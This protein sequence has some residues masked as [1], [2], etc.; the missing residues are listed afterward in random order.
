[1]GQTL[2]NLGNPNVTDPSQARP[3]D[4]DNSEKSARLI[5]G[6]THGLAQGFQNYNQ[7]KQGM[8]GG[9]GGRAMMQP[10]TGAQPVD[11]SYFAPQGLAG[12]QQNNPFK[13]MKG[14]N[15]AFYGG[16]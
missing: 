1:M 10:A 5:A 15:L 8:Q 11:Q 9:G 6:T 7:Q 14:N 12:Q 3:Q 4:L 2:G 16:S 13:P